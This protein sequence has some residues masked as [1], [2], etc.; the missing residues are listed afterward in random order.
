MS[1][2]DA[3]QKA[4]MPELDLWG[5]GRNPS[6]H[7]S[8]SAS[9]TAGTTDKKP[10]TGKA[11]MEAIVARENMLL[12]LRAVERNAGAPGVDGT[13]TGQLRSYLR[14]HWEQVKRQL[15][16]GEYQPQAVRRVD[17]PKP[18]GGSRMLGIPTVLDRLIQQAIHQVLSP[19]WE[20]DFSENSYGFRPGR[21]AHGAV[22]AARG[23][24][25]AG[26]RWVVD[27]DLE[28]FFDRVNHDVLMARVSRK[29]EDKRV[30]RL[31]RRYLQSGIME[32]GVVGVRSEGTPQGG[33]LSP[34]L[35]N[36]LLDDLDKELERRG[37]R[38]CRYADDCNIYVKS[39]RAGERVKESIKA[40]LMGKLKLKVNEAKSRV[41]RPWESKFLGYSMTVERRPRLKAAGESVKRFRDKVCQLTRRGRGR[42]MERVIKEDLNPL[43][44]GWANYYRKA[45]T[46]GVFEELDGWVRRKL[47]CL[48]WRRWKRVYTRAR[49]LISLGFAE[50]KAWRCA[51]NGRGPWWNAGSSHM[52][53]AYPAGVFRRMGLIS[54]LET[55]KGH[56]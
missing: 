19:V 48:I 56:A 29:I 7:R 15:L 25:E 51:C 52:N 20:P 18:G 38:F 26:H 9:K 17:I 6:E 37:H 42:N 30:L 4:E 55:V 2:R 50:A 36:I 40:F 32:G 10:A 33:P 45:M 13:T 34:L 53:A 44:R 22:E 14:T 24:V 54:I 35:S 43:L 31:I 12:A 27:L 41:A 47:R 1:E 8:M 39:L 46:Y 3:D 5:S 49:R 28:K 16:A 21:S 11:S 23:H